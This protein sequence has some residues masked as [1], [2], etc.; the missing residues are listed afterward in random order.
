MKLPKYM[1]LKDNAR[2][3]RKNMTETERILWSRLKNKKMNGVNFNRQIVIGNYIVDFYC[4]SAKLVIEIDGESHFLKG[5]YDVQRNNYLL[6]QGL[7]VIHISDKDVRYKLND[8]LM[9]I[10]SAVERINM[11][12]VPDADSIEWFF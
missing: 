11:G 10:K 4:P 5:E 1:N 6:K 2:N 8:V 7:Y 12:D 9:F 3:L